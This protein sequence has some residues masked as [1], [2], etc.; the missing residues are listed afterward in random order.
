MRTD[1]T[2]F[3]RDDVRE[4]PKEEDGTSDLNRH[5]L[6]DKYYMV[7]ALKPGGWFS[8]RHTFP[9]S[10]RGVGRLNYTRPPRYDRGRPKCLKTY[11]GFVS[12]E[13]SYTERPGPAPRFVA[14][15]GVLNSFFT[16][17]PL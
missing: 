1:S 13:C 7:E 10:H 14:V 16:A 2:E 12:V 6:R 11:F 9:N 15:Y 5:D 17:V 8:R 3:P 4:C